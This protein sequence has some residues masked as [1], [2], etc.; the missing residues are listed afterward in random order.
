MLKQLL[1]DRILILHNALVIVGIIH[2]WTERLRQPGGGAYTYAWG[3][4]MRANLVI[5]G[6][7][8][9][10][11]FLFSASTSSLF[12][13]TSLV[14]SLEGFGGRT[15]HPIYL[16]SCGFEAFLIIGM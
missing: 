10:T 14:A 5:T 15:E 3:V 7:E 6:H 4:V 12:Y 8:Y 13:G 16:G 9:E 2:Y 11:A 1:R